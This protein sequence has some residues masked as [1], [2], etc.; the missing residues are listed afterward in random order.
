MKKNKKKTKER[1]EAKSQEL[2]PL[3]VE[4]NR[5][6]QR[7]AVAHYIG[8]VVIIVAWLIGWK[9]GVGALVFGLWSRFWYDQGKFSLCCDEYEVGGYPKIGMRWMVKSWIWLAAFAIVANV[10]Y[11][12]C[13]A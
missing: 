10:I 4:I 1:S 8:G 5:I 13:Y 3:E 7:E 9:W 11:E 6:A 12:C 2:T